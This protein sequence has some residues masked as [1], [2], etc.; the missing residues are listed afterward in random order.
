MDAKL[1]VQLVLNYWIID[2]RQGHC[3]A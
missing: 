2:Y 3:G 1:P